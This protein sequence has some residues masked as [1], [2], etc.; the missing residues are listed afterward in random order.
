[1]L[2]HIKYY[3]KIGEKMVEVRRENIPADVRKSLQSYEILQVSKSKV[4]VALYGDE[5]DPLILLEVPRN[6]LA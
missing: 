4:T 3:I 5:E 6:M 2:Q 1:M